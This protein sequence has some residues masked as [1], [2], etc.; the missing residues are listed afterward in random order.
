MPAVRLLNAV[1]KPPSGTPGSSAV[2][3]GFD[4]RVETKPNLQA[5]RVAVVWTQNGWQTVNHTEC[6]LVETPNDTD[7]WAASI[8][9]Y[10][11]PNI[12]F[13]YAI[14]A[15]GPDGISWDNNG[16]WNYLI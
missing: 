5:Y 15:A 11:T 10:S 8:S 4:A 7:I 12:T 13:F 2:E 14:A 6:K 16:G 1:K 9:Y 3:R